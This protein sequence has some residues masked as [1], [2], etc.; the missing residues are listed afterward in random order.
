MEKENSGI[1]F[2]CLS[3]TLKNYIIVIALCSQFH[4]ILFHKHGM[5]QEPVP[6]KRNGVGGYVLIFPSTNQCYKVYVHYKKEQ[7][8]VEAHELAN[9]IETS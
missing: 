8:H 4:H 9:V 3:Q 1:C 6:L 2:Q 7:T 5:S